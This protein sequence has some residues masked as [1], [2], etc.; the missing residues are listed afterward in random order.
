MQENTDRWADL[1]DGQ[2][3]YGKAI[4]LATPKMN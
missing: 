4:A 2:Y 3:N 1:E